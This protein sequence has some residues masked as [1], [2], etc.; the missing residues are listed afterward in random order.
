MLTWS[1]QPCVIGPHSSYLYPTTFQ[2]SQGLP[3][4]F[5]P[6]RMQAKLF[7]PRG[8]FL[9]KTFCLKCSSPRSYMTSCFTILM[10]QLKGPLYIGFSWPQHLKHHLHLHCPGTSILSPHIFCVLKKP[11]VLGVFHLPLQIH[12][13]FCCVPPGAVLNRLQQQSPLSSGW[14]QPMKTLAE[15]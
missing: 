8:F 7:P 6:S 2:P 1:A 3:S 12:S 13:P 4:S 14:I 11:I 10:R 15:D 9:C 5:E